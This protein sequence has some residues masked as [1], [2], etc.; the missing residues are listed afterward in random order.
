MLN[1]Y[2]WEFC[3]F[4][5]NT[6][7]V[8]VFGGFSHLNWYCDS[9]L[10]LCLVSSMT[11]K[12]VN[13]LD[14]LD[15]P[16]TEPRSSQTMLSVCRFPLP[17]IWPEVESEDAGCSLI[18]KTLVGDLCY[19]SKTKQHHAVSVDRSFVQSIVKGLT[20]WTLINR[21]K[22]YANSIRRQKHLFIVY[23]SV[24]SMML[25]SG[26]FKN[27]LYRIDLSYSDL[28]FQ[29]QDHTYRA[30]TLIICEHF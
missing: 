8:L 1:L 12:H 20:R 23:N 25:E 27:T 16:S 4:S 6:L 13:K 5:L 14:C 7:S 28:N 3:F 17:K 11:I 29:I 24:K 18:R 10:D 19:S 30:V 15:C 2:I 22:G 26:L 9:T 21:E